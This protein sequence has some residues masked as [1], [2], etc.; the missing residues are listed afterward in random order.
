MRYSTLVTLVALCAG[1]SALPGGSGGG[2]KDD[3]VCIV[4]AGPAG[5]S[6]AKVL[7]EK[8]K[9][10]VVFEKQPEVG[11]KCQAY[12]ENGVFHPL[13]AVIYTKATYTETVKIIELTGTPYENFTTYTSW[14]YNWTTGAVEPSPAITAEIAQAIGI[15]F[16]KY[17]QLWAGSFAPL[18]GIGY[19][20]SRI[21]CL[22][23]IACRPTDTIAERCPARACSASGRVVCRERPQLPRA[24]HQRCHGD[25]WVRRLE[26][27]TH[28]VCGAVLHARRPRQLYTAG[29]AIHCRLPRGLCTVLEDAEGAC[30][31][32]SRH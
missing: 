16:Q 30:L 15:D 14:V 22:P 28:A 8:G 12:Y 10:V 11:G 27:G 2:G 29:P 4:G 18:S 26:R 23:L 1:S 32:R 31:H 3:P 13:G 9:S 6:A 25:V 7:E 24:R 20:V 21:D 19:K 17:G 5:L